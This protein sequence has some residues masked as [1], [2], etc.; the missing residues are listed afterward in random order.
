M[1]SLI[2]AVVVCSSGA[3]GCDGDLLGDALDAERELE[4]QGAAELEDDAVLGLRREAGQRRGEVP[5]PDAQRRKEE[6]AFCVGDALDARAA[7]GVRGG[8]GGAGQHAARAVPD[9][10]ADLAGVELSRSRTDQQQPGCHAQKRAS[11]EPIGILPLDRQGANRYIRLPFMTRVRSWKAA[12]VGLVMGVLGSGGVLARQ[13]PTLQG[14]PE[15]Y[16]R[17]DIEYGARLYAQHC[18]GAMAPMATASPEWRCAT[19]SSGMPSP[20]HS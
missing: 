17:A 16:P 11:H 20:I 7:G 4:L 6:A 12:I 15:D 2:S 19:A 14:H 3:V 13:N 9:H 5:L 10:A 1:T 8:D 18:F